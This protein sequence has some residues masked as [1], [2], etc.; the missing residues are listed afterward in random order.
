[1]YIINSKVG[2]CELNNFSAEIHLPTMYYK[3]VS[4]DFQNTK[5][6]IPLDIYSIESKTATGTSKKGVYTIMPTTSKTTIR[7]VGE[8]RAAATDPMTTLN[9]NSPTNAQVSKRKT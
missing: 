4:A 9:E 5:I 8:K 6:Y 3:S 1:M 2:N 7:V